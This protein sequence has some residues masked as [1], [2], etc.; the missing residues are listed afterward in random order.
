VGDLGSV[1]GV[2]AGVLS[3]LA[4]VPYVASILR[5]QTRPNRA[6]WWVWTVCNGILFASYYAAGER[7]SAWVPL[8]FTVASL[9]V[10]LLSLKRG[11]GGLSRFDRGCVLSCAAGLILW[12]L[13]GSPLTA[14]VINIGVDFAGALPTIRKTYLDP[15]SESLSA[16]SLFLAANAVN[17]FA[18]EAW[19]SPSIALPIYYFLITLVIIALAAR[20]PRAAPARAPED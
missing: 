17:L 2:L 7:R 6:T 1:L 11:E 14:L 19:S 20:S 10:A 18:V 12:G 13:S 8:S 5:G 15:K 16:W 4:F 9:F 3:L